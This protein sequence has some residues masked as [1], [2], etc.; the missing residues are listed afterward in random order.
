MNFVDFLDFNLIWSNHTDFNTQYVLKSWNTFCRG[1]SLH[2]KHWTITGE[3]DVLRIMNKLK[4][5]KSKFYFKILCREYSPNF[6]WKVWRRKLRNVQEKMRKVGNNWERLRNNW[7]W[8]RKIENVGS[9]RDQ[10][11]NSVLQWSARHIPIEQSRLLLQ[12]QLK[13]CIL[14]ETDLCSYQTVYKFM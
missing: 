6:F 4:M 10:A 7:E 14:S 8:L 12:L 9:V 5:A 13:V 11:W 2:R 1:A 3:K